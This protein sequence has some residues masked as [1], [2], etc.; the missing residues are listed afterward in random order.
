PHKNIE[1]IFK[2][3]KNFKNYDEYKLVFSG[4]MDHQLLNYAKKYNVCLS[5]IQT[6]GLDANDELLDKYY[7]TATATILTSFEEGFG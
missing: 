5:N 6:I 2:A 3:F 4:E 7:K 1:I